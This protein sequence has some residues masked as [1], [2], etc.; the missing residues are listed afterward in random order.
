MTDRS[1]FTPTNYPLTIPLDER[2][3]VLSF[4]AGASAALFAVLVY[5]EL[6]F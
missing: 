6:R 3:S 4:L 2:F 5:L 1:K